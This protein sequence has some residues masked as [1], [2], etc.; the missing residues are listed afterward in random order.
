MAFMNN[1]GG[2]NNNQQSNNGEPKKKVNFKVGKDIYGDDGRLTV[3][4]WNSDKGGTYATLRITSAVGKDP[5]TK[6]N[7]Y[8]QKMSGE[9]PTVYLNGENLCVLMMA[10]ADT[11]PEN[12][13]FTIDC[14]RSK[15]TFKGAGTQ[16][17]ITIENQKTGSRTITLKSIP[18]GDK[19]YHPSWK[20][21]LDKLKIVDKKIAFGSVDMD[22]FGVAFTNSD[23]AT[24]E[25]DDTPF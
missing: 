15:I 1:N 14:G 9:L 24:A 2:F 6:A 23:A 8:E 21:L 7:V 19:N 17:T 22:E 5:S 13:D 3:G 25:S 11:T 16:Y 20:L 10:M 18:A 4:T 12:C